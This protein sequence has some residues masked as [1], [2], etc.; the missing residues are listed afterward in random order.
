M[1]NA[2]IAD[3]FENI[4]GLLE[5][6]EE[7][8]F[9]VRAYQ[10]AARTIERLPT[11]LTQMVGEEKDL[12]ELPGIG[13]A[14]ADKIAEL[15][16]TGKLGYYE[17]LK[18]K[19]PPGVLEMMNIPGLGPKTIVRVWKELEVTTIAELERAARDGRLADMPRL[20]QKTAENILRELQFA[21]TK[22][23][24]VP[25]GRARPVAERLMAALRER[26]PTITRIVAAG[27]LRRFE[28]T[29]GDVDLVCTAGE[30][31]E[32]LDA[33][34]A[35]PEVAEV[36]GHG[37][38]KASVVLDSGIQVDLR[39]VED[40]RFGSLLQY[41]TGSQQHNI[42]LRDYANRMGLSLNEYGITDMATGELQEFSDEEGFY[43]RLGL[44]YIP[45]ELRTGVAEIEAARQHR[46]PDLVQVS[47]LRGDL[48][49]HTDWSD[50]RDPMEVMIAAAKARGLQYVAITDHSA[51][52][53]IANG[54]S[55]ER[56]RRHMARLRALEQ[57]IGGVRV[58]CGTE[59]DIRADGTLDYADEVL[60]ELDWVIAS[61]HS[62]MGQ[63]SEKMTQ[64]IIE[65]M[66]NPYV[67]AIGHLS[68]R[69][70]GERQPINADFE[71]LFRAA[72]ETGTALEINASPER[73]DLKDTHIY[74]ARE[75]GVPLV[76]NTDAHTVEMLDN[77]RYG[78]A[79]ARRGWCEAKHILNCRPVEEFMSFL[80]T[81]KPKR[82]KVFA[83][84]GA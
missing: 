35:L 16:N 6:E 30:P 21:R 41:F 69:L 7:S 44:Q 5:M 2:Q 75:L 25:I 48:H 60:K 4:A 52:R 54:L 29:I 50:G 14:I 49:V 8:V 40:Q 76:I 51:G 57:Q 64:R 61:V 17:R 39:V 43:E 73:L 77:A 23:Q 78:G 63:D 65:A 11:E 53:G 84:H 59:M 46:I 34:V 37:G 62:A 79:V 20:G 81:D 74:R 27:S 67:S 1:D 47:D 22:D 83:D 42:R 70:I 45:P 26:C 3:V 38:T 58:L 68:T 66:R 12:R 9:T 28:E 36:L 13:K 32:P 10:R 72:A 80:A 33:L 31:T 24:R 71:A 56:L 82:T 19:F 15:V 55:P 18:A